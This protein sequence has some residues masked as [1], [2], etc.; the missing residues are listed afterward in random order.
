MASSGVLS[1]DRRRDGR[2]A[3]AAHRR[4]AGGCSARRRP[5][6]C[7]LRRRVRAGPNRIPRDWW[8]ATGEA[9]RGALARA[10][11]GGGAVSAV[12]F[13]G[14]MHGSTLLDE[15]DEVVRP[16]LLWCDQRTE[17]RVRRD[18]RAYRRRA[19]HRAHA[20]TRRSPASRFPSC[21]GSARHEPELWARVRSVLLPKDYVRFRLTGDRATD[22]ADASGTLLFDVTH[23]RW[24]REVAAAL[25]IDMSLLPQAYE[26]PDDHRP[27]QRG[28][29]SRNRPARRHAGR[30][31]RRRSGCRRGRHGD[32]RTG[33]VSATIG[34]S[35]VV[36][37][38]TDRP[39]LDP[40]GRAPHLLPRRARP[41]AHDG[42]DARGRPVAA[43]VP[44]SGWAAACGRGPTLTS[45]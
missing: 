7:R 31:R 34:T 3:R 1:R 12:G 39:A 38:A 8:R 18:H 41:L 24:S 29:R 26:S 40:Q 16:A 10:G 2:H 27:R 17:R 45:G 23:R 9:V 5:S 43:L 32:R 28:G 42:R 4:G 11:V 13:S 36:F 33:L 37:A 6:T 44:R 25:D 21:S 20:R 30:R 15:R 19:P 22:V 35:G 14:Q